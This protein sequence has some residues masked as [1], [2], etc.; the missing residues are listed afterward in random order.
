MKLNKLK[1]YYR[2]QGE[3]RALKKFNSLLESIQTENTI[4]VKRLKFQID[5]KIS[6]LEAK[7]DILNKREQKLIQ[8]QENIDLI[9]AEATRY[10]KNLQEDYHDERR[11][12]MVRRKYDLDSINHLH[13]KSEKLTNNARLQ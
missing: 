1:N 10:Y 9:N 7:E 5:K 8:T 11:Q 12:K 3:A 2:V 6:E 13:A 4:E